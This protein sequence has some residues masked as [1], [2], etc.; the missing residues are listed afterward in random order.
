MLKFA[1]EN[2]VVGFFATLIR[3]YLGYTWITNS[4]AKISAGGFDATGFM[5]GAIANSR[6][7]NPAVYSWWANFLETVALP[8]G[9][10]FSFMVMWGEFL[11]GLAL[12]IGLLTQFALIMGILMNASFIL[13]G[14]SYPDIQMLILALILIVCV[15]NAYKIGLDRWALP[16]LRTLIKKISFSG[17]MNKSI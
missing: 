1:R 12:I 15:Q 13:S 8:N 11:V 16:Y 17:K 9:E 3:I 2:R 10:L 5:Q 4:W 6:G 14:A 7:E